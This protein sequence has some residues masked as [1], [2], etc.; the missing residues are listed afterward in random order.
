M[1]EVEPWDVPAALCD[2]CL[3]MLRVHEAGARAAMT[4]T[5]APNDSRHPQA[6]VQ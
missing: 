3:E 2:L 6:T 4:S 5:N 1:P